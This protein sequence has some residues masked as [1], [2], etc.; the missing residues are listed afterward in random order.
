MLFPSH[1]ISDQYASR[2]IQLDDGRQLT[3]LLVAGAGDEMIVLKSDGEK[4]SVDKSEII[5]TKLSAVS[6]MPEG[7]LN[8]LELQEIADLFVY[9]GVNKTTAMAK[10]PTPTTK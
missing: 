1:V 8:E 10:K 3:G 9:M 7:L 2:I 4:V 6:S 5:R